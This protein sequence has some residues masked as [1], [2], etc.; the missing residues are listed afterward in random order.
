MKR[1]ILTATAVV[2]FAAA[3]HADAISDIQAQ[4]KQLRDRDQALVK[5]L[6]DLEKRAERSRGQRSRQAGAGRQFGRRV[7]RRYCLTRRKPQS[8]AVDD[9]VCLNGVCLYSFIDISLTY[10]NHGAPLNSIVSAPLD[11]MISRNAGNSYFGV[12]ANALSTS[13]IGLRR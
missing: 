2:A 4:T 11:Y 8:T 1:A 6:A 7:C 9:G 12:G 13:F 5:R 3:G 10:Q